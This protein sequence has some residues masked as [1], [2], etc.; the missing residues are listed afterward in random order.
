MR[1][2]HDDGPASQDHEVAPDDHLLRPLPTSEL[3]LTGI[4]T[5]IDV[6]GRGTHG[7]GGFR[8]HHALDH[9]VGD[10][11]PRCSAALF[12]PGWTWE[13]REA[14]PGRTWQTWWADELKF[15]IAARPPAPIL[16][17]APSV[18]SSSATDPIPA[19]STS[20]A[21]L[22]AAVQALS[23]DDTTDSDDEQRDLMPGFY[24]S[25]C[26]HS[27]YRPIAHFFPA[28]PAL[29]PFATVFC[30]GVGSGWFISG[31][32]V[33][34]APWTE[35]AFQTHVPTTV[36]L[37]VEL[38]DAWMGSASVRMDGRFG[39][40]GIQKIRLDRGQAQTLVLSLTW[41]P[42]DPNASAVPSIDS[43]PG[44][45]SPE[46]YVADGDEKVD[47]DETPL[48]NGWK[49]TSATW[50]VEPDS[51]AKHVLVGVKLRGARADVVLGAYA[52]RVQDQDEGYSTA[53]INEFND[54]GGWTRAVPPYEKS[55]AAQSHA[56]DI[57]RQLND[58]DV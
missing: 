52:V 48:S 43:K 15:W 32:R 21:D 38:D 44:A 22:S 57:S 1:A 54:A 56:V 26:K 51:S 37:Q 8:C 29:L 24:P 2:M 45:N 11:G 42:L 58:L 10:D 9:I 50:P 25:Q 33:S 35:V 23:S 49:M 18:A 4:F 39:A 17:L 3:A 36:G 14:E 53:W 13:N 20:A 27:K 7:G 47:F 19:L 41:K 28:Q 34:N 40:V 55:L 5:G 46:E 6:W 31:K 16:S 30:P 12:A